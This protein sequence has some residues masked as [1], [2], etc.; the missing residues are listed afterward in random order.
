LATNSTI[1]SF[2]TTPESKFEVGGFDYGVDTAG[3]SYSL[4]SPDSQTLRFEVRPGDYASYDSSSVDRSEISGDYIPGNTPIGIN[5]QFMVEPNGTNNTFTNTASWLLV[6]QMHDGGTV[7]GTS[8]P[9]AMQLEGNHLQL[10]AR[11]VEPGGN[12]SNGSSDLHMLTLWTDPNPIV[13]GQYYD[14]NIQANVS[15]TGGGLLKLSVNGQQVVNYSG[16]LG[17][18]SQTHW[19]EGVYRNAGPTETVTAD[20]RNLMLTTEPS[21]TGVASRPRP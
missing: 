1:T 21:R 14:I 6:G 9:F 19:E 8:P 15:N 18:G 10:V 7:T 5:Y 4:T 3:K 2:S 11:Y 12:P 20:F 17:Y 16:P 13:P